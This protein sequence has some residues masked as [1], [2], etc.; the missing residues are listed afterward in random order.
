[1][2]LP[3]ALPRAGPTGGRAMN[4]HLSRRAALALA[5]FAAVSLALLGFFSAS[6]GGPS[7]GGGGTRVRSIVA[8][9]EGI[10]TGA[11]V[12]VRGVRVGKVAAEP[13]AGAQTELVL[14]LHAAPRLHPDATVRIGS[15]TPLGEPFVDL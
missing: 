2:R 15:K 12:L 3:R 5:L 13:A 11:D 9:A 6:F 4:L 7:I 14:E 8:D 1:R 10:P